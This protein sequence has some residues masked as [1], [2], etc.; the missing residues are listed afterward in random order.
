MSKALEITED[1]PYSSISG[2]TIAALLNV[3]GSLQLTGEVRRITEVLAEEAMTQLEEEIKCCRYI[4][5]YSSE[6]DISLDIL[7]QIDSFIE[8]C[9]VQGQ[10]VAEFKTAKKNSSLF[11]DD[12]TSLLSNVTAV[13]EEQTWFNNQ[14]HELSELFAEAYKEGESDWD[15]ISSG[16]STAES[17]TALF[18]GTVP[19][20][21][22]R[23]ACAQDAV[24]DS[25]EA[26]IAELLKL[27]D[28]SEPKLS[29]FS[30]QFD[31]DDLIKET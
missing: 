9:G 2:E 17:L 19:E 31:A 29:A 12:I 22:I 1:F 10:Y 16:L 6:S 14:R 24:D 15:A 23:I 8:N 18:E 4:S 26:N 28:E 5:G 27:V 30:A 11:Y 3:T 25:F 20:T 7:P 21:I 13:K